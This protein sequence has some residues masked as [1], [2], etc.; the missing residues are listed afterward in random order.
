MDN[1]INMKNSNYIIN[2]ILSVAVIV[3]FVL[4]FT[5]KGTFSK[6]PAAAV[7]VT[8]SI[9]YNL[10]IAYVNTDSL[11][12][13]YKFY[14]DLNDALMRKRDDK[15]L[16]IRRQE[17]KFK[18]EVLDYSEKLERNSFYTTERQQQ[19]ENRL[20]RMRQ[21]LENFAA[22][23]EQE[24]GVEQSYML[25]QLAD[26]IKAALI[27]FNNPKKYELIFSNAGTDN[28]LYAGDS[29]NITTEVTEFLNARYVPDKK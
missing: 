2:G 4:Y 27:D 24:I 29:Y 25:R 12:T 15:L 19:E 9:G 1:F 22:Q 7:S 14:N 8:D 26:T 21:E 10:P 11:L 17:D 23:A 20:T 5:S 13:N 6:G 16:A 18:K 28:I 3:L